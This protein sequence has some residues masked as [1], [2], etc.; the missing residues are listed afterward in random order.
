MVNFN[1][2][3]NFIA[4]E[5]SLKFEKINSKSI[6]G[7]ILP[8]FPE[9]K[10]DIQNLMSELNEICEKVNKLNKEEKQEELK[11]YEN[12]K[13]E[14]SNF[15]NKKKQPELKKIKAIVF[16]VDGV[17]I[18]SCDIKGKIITKFYTENLNLNKEEIKKISFYLNRKLQFK[19][20]N[21]NIK[22]IDIEKELNLLNE[23]LKQVENDFLLNEKLVNFIKSNYKNYLFFTNTM[24]PHNSLEKIFKNHNLHKYFKELFS[25]DTGLKNENLEKISKKYDLKYEEIIFIDDSKGHIEKSKELKINTIHFT[26]LNIDMKNQIEKFEKLINF[27]ELEKSNFNEFCFRFSPAPSG[28]LHIGHMF[29]ILFNYIYKKKYGGKFILRIEDTNPENIDISN[30]EAIINDVNFLTN[31]EIDEVF[32]QSDRIEIYYN[33]L[34]SAIENGSAYFDF[35]KNEDKKNEDISKLETRCF[36]KYR[37]STPKENLIIFENVLNKKYKEGEVLLRFKGDLE[38]KNPALWDFGIARI[39]YAKHQRLKDKYHFWPMYNFCCSIDDSLMKVSH[40]IRGKDGE[41]NAVKQDMIKNSLDLKKSIYSHIGRVNFTNLELSKTKIQNKINEKEFTGWEDPRTYSITS[42]KKKGYKA[43]SFFN[44]LLEKG[45][46]KRDS[47]LSKEEF[48][49]GVN[50]FN[51]QLIDETS[52]RYFCVEK[53]IKLEIENLK[54]MEKEFNKTTIFILHGTKGNINDNWFKW[55]KEN[56]ENYNYKII[57]ENYPTPENQNLETW[58]KKLNEFEDKINKNTIFVCHSLSVPFILNYLEKT[59]KK[60]KSCYFIGGFLKVSVDEKR[61]KRNKTFMK[62]TFNFEKIKNNC[63][64]FY[65]FNSVD[66]PYIPIE[67]GIELCKK[68]EGTFFKYEKAGHFT[69]D[70]GFGKFEDLNNLIL[71]NENKKISIQIEKFPQKP[72]KGFRKLNINKEIFIEENDLKKLE[73]GDIFRLMHL[74]NFKKLENNKIKFLSKEYSKEIKIKSNIHFVSEFEECQIINNEN[75]KTNCYLEKSYDLQI[76]EICQFERKGFFIFDRL[77]SSCGK[78]KFLFCHR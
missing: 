6:I 21:E 71:K 13:K 43:E 68:V 38:S 58:L 10:K 59:N 35:T 65:S 25:Y 56:L 54:E 42:F 23:K 15:S 27:T 26:N 62:E 8:K 18:D 28:N 74:G 16:D 1:E 67:Q 45:I 40:I 76:G 69:L 41:I 36:L 22:K 73:V 48:L 4:L 61:D 9:K 53:P 66:D 7:K 11:K 39:K 32:Y 52:N 12:I 5:N 44:Y 77:G 31:N 14:Y 29:N 55:L 57:L 30:Y 51:K 3:V 63:K 17:I 72:E 2:F 47:K 20:I 50:F 34:K 24:M 19:F 64:N 70:S 37:N 49:K 75:E 46:S 60:I 78:K 33:Y